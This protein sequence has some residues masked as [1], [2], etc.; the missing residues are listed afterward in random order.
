MG[1]LCRRHRR[2]RRRRRR[3]HTIL[4]R[5]FILALAATLHDAQT[6]EFCNLNSFLPLFD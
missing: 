3:R 5:M 6:E 4:S 1:V 2:R